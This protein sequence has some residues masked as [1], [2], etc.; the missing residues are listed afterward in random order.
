MSQ[1]AAPMDVAS[2]RKGTYVGQLL[3]RSAEGATRELSDQELWLYLE[4]EETKVRKILGR[5]V[6]CTCHQ[7]W[8]ITPGAKRGVAT[9]QSGSSDELKL[10]LCPMSQAPVAVCMQPAG[11]FAATDVL[12]DA[13]LVLRDCPSAERMRTQLGALMACEQAAAANLPGARK[14][15]LQVG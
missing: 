1:P 13:L 6:R 7:R 5:V 2:V 15:L 12:R 10:Y 9:C 8:H 4:S 3:M 14:L 11:P